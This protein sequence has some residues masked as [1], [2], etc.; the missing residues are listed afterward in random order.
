MPSRAR[1]ITEMDSLFKI[2]NAVK[3]GWHAD[4]SAGRSMAVRRLL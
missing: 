1:E 4:V 3:S 2:D